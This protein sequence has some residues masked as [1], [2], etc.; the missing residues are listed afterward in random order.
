MRSFEAESRERLSSNIARTISL[1]ALLVQSYSALTHHRF[2]S[3]SDTGF[4]AKSGMPFNMY[5][6]VPQGSIESPDV[7]MY[8]V[9]NSWSAHEI[10]GP[11]ARTRNSHSRESPRPFTSTANLSA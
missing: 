2:I 4:S 10:L 11:R 9:E 5:H 1:L 3:S 6:S 7:I 8:I